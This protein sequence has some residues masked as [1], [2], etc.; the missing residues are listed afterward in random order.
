MILDNLDFTDK[1]VIEKLSTLNTNKKELEELRTIIYKIKEYRMQESGAHP[2]E[3]EFLEFLQ[4]K[5][6]VRQLA[7]EN[8]ILIYISPVLEFLKKLENK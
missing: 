8:Y 6:K 4:K 7:S 3:E 1:Q 5:E 2:T